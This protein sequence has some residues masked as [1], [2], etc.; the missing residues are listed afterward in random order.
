[1]LH[2]EYVRNLNCNYE[3]ILLDE[4]PEEI[5]LDLD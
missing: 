5:L 3:R 1:M 4:K 2:I